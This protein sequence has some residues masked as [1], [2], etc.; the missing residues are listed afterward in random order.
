MMARVYDQIQ[1]ALEQAIAD[2]SGT[3]RDPATG[4]MLVAFENDRFKPETGVEW[5]RVQFVPVGAEPGSMGENGYTRLDGELV[6]DLFFPV[7]GGSGPTRKAAADLTQYFRRAQTM[8]SADGV[9]VWIRGARR[10]PGMVEDQWHHIQ[11]RV[12]WTVHRT[13]L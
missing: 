12:H 7:G 9:D 8:T 4:K 6:I 3:P 11:V 1:S 2:Y 5:W 10:E 13:E